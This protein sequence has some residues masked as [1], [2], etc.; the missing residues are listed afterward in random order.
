MESKKKYKL[1]CM[2]CLCVLALYDNRIFDSVL[3][4]HVKQMNSSNTFSF[5]KPESHTPRD[6]FVLIP[7]S[8]VSQLDYS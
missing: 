3:Q 1:G 6:S 2:L 8:R 5:S 4:K 7:N